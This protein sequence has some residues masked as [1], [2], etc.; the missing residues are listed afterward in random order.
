M[1]TILRGPPATLTP[2]QMYVLVAEHFRS[3]FWSSDPSKWDWSLPVHLI[4]GVPGW[5][6]ARLEAVVDLYHNGPAH[7]R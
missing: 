6:Q 4:E 7:C 3:A 5:T 2:Q 1:K